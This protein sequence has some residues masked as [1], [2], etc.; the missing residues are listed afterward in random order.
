MRSVSQVLLSVSAVLGTSA[1]T[2]KRPLVR[3]LDLPE[4]LFD[5]VTSYI[6]RSSALAARCAD[7]QVLRNPWVLTDADS[8]QFL[9]EPDYR[10]FLRK[11]IHAL[12]VYHSPL[13][14]S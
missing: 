5:E 7:G 6:D 3:M 1:H 13:T 14:S 4:V 11:C 10:R 12:R 9:A 2:P 8:A